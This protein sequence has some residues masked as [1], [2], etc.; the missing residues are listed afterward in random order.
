MHFTNIELRFGVVVAERD[1]LNIFK[2][3]TDNTRSGYKK[4]FSSQTFL[5]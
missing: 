3:L 5:L 1:S 2:V 4:Y